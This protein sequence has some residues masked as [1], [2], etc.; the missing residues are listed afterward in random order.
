[1]K[2][3]QLVVLHPQAPK[4]IHEVLS[5]YVFQMGS[6]HCF[7]AIEIAPGPFFSEFGATKTK[8]GNEY[9]AWKVQLPN[10]YILAIAETNKKNPQ[11]GFL[12]DLPHT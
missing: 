9:L 6:L 5:D 12:S 4:E 7:F 2:R 11:I 1:M 3:P 8:E 10:S